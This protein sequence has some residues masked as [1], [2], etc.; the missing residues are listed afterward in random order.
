MSRL[1]HHLTP[2][3]PLCHLCLYQTIACFRHSVIGT[4]DSS[5]LPVFWYQLTGTRNW[6][7]CPHL[8]GG[9]CINPERPERLNC[10]WPCIN[11]TCQLTKQFEKFDYT[12]ISLAVAENLSSLL[13]LLLS[14]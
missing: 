6:S 12:L 8:Y 3:S 9:Q 7:D 14:N 10:G 4:G 2:F 11:L 1:T 13:L 5:R